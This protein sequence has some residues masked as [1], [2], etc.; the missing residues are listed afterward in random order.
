MV[1]QDLP[2]LGGHP[3]HRRGEQGLS[4]GVVTL[5]LHPV[6]IHPFVGGVLVDQIDHI[7][8]FHNDI[9]VEDLSGNPPGKFLRL[10]GKG[11]LLNGGA[12]CGRTV[13]CLPR[14]GGFRW[15]IR[16]R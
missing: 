7:A 3:A 8:L 10:S 13:D 5:C 1:Q 15:L 12:G 11:L 9:G 14:P 2:F 6:E 4:H 16:G